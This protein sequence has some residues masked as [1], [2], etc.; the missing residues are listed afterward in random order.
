MLRLI[1]RGLVDG[2]LSSLGV[3]I[4]A[5]LSNDMAIVLSAGLSGAVANGFS[6]IMA[7]FTA[8]KTGRYVD[9]NK[10]EKKMMKSL[11]GTRHERAIEKEVMKG[12]IYDGVASFFGGAI[13]ILPFLFLDGTAALSTAI[14]LVGVLA[15]V[16]GINTSL[17]SREN[18]FFSV[19]KML[20]FTFATAG[21]CV[22]I[23]YLF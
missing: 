2:A 3:V 7:A 4:G 9:L 13:P 16:L 19:T 20:V 12:G 22:S 1:I 10:L 6:N 21:I 5:S 14:G 8:E 23:Q 11:K 15:V 18:M 17:H